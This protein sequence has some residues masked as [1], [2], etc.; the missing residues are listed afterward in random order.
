MVQQDV[1]RFAVI[2]EMDAARAVFHHVLASA[3]S[4]SLHRRSDGTRW[5]NEEL[6]FHML[7]GY[8]IVRALLTL[9]RAFS[10]LPAPVSRRFAAALNFA[11][12]PFHAVNYWGTR[13]GALAYSTITGWGPKLDRVVASLQRRVRREHSAG[14]GPVDE[15]PR[16]V[17]SV[18]SNPR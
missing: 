2:R 7:F 12:V 1:D 10:R 3:D 8:L 5:T 4:A 9:V 16:R 18:L 11:T 14:P 13:L 15:L 6:L 17:G